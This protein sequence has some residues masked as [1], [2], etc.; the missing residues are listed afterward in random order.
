MIIFQRHRDVPYL[1]K[2]LPALP[3][4]NPSDLGKEDPL[5][6]LIK[7]V[8]LRIAETLLPPLLAEP[9]ETTPAMKKIPIRLIQI[10]QNLLQN[11][12]MRL[13]QKTCRRFPLPSGQLG[14]QVVVVQILL[15]VLPGI[16]P[17]SQGLVPHEAAAPGKSPHEC[18]LFSRWTKLK[19]IPLKNFHRL[20]ILGL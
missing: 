10:L 18:F 13:L 15:F 3:V 8:P 19:F 7:P 17:E 16:T 2:D 6:T 1:P 14:S 20:I 11:L 4:S 9:G 12:G 5:I